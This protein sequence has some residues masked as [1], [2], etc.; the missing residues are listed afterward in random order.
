MYGG[1]HEK[2]AVLE[3]SRR[4]NHKYIVGWPNQIPIRELKFTSSSQ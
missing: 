4:Q 3:A 2:F 1:V